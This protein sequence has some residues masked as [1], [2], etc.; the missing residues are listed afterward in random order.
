MADN[1][2]SLSPSGPGMARVSVEAP[3]LTLTDP[4][5]PGGLPG[6]GLVG[7]IIADYLVAE[8]ET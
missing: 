1:V 8:F 2:I 3:D 7:K 6:K 4:I 5:M